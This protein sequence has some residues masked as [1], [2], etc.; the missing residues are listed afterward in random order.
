VPRTVPL[1][2]R[3]VAQK[4]TMTRRP[5]HNF[6]RTSDLELLGDGFSRFMHDEFVENRTEKTI[7]KPLTSF[8]E[9]FFAF[10]YNFMK[11]NS[12]VDEPSANLFLTS[13]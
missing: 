5:A 4:V 1:P 3:L 9:T 2:S 13:Q 8:L 11:S 6:A 12:G 10:G 7:P